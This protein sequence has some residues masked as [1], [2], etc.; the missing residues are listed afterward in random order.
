MLPAQIIEALDAAVKVGLGLTTIEIV[1]VSIHNPL[2]PA[3]VY[4]VVTLGV[5]TK[6]DPIVPSGDNVYNVAPLGINVAELPEQTLGLEATIFKV[7][8][9]VT[10]IVKVLMFIHPAAD[11]P[12][13]L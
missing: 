11:S 2:L 12:I 5:T 3:M 13:I 1:S 9:V 7:G 10:L 4:V 6:V 8:V